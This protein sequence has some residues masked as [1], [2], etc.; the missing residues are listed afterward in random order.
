MTETLSP[1]TLEEL[2]RLGTCVVSNAIEQFD[3]RLRNEGFT[4]SS[5]HCI[6]PEQPA[7]IGYAVTGR[8]RSDMAPIGAPAS[9]VHAGVF[10][11]RTDWW[12]HILSIPG[13]RIVALQDIGSHPGHAAFWGKV[14]ANIHLRLGCV[15]AVTNGAVRFVDQVRHIGFQLFASGVT[16][17]HSYVHL[18]DFGGPVKIAGLPVSTGDVLLADQHGV[19]QI[20]KNIAAEIPKVAREAEIRRRRIIDFCRSEPFSLERLRQLVIESDAPPKTE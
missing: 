8:I 12:E 18:V 19:L 2:R 13:P 5:I 20:P 1:E 3:V 6:F 4:D 17:S 15:G 11:E 9:A 16:V 7:I 14:H 10:L